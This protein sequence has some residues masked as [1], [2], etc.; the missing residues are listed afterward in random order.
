MH[1][2]TYTHAGIHTC[3]HTRTNR[4]LLSPVEDH[5]TFEVLM[6][7]ANM[8]SIVLAVGT[9]KATRNL[10]NDCPDV[11]NYTKSINAAR[12]IFPHW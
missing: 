6:A 11:K 4:N 7:P 1:T 5:V 3:T 8:P 9:Q 10:L 2:R 12:D